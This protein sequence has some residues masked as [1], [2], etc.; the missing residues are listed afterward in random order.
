M[1]F[2]GGF[3]ENHKIT[4]NLEEIAPIK[5]WLD[6]DGWFKIGNSNIGIVNVQFNKENKI[7]S[8]ML[9]TKVW[10]ILFLV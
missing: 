2:P 9:I 10:S 6:Y 7:N 8:N 5:N 1:N 4:E 3:H